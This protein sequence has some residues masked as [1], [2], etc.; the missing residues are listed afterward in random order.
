MVA[1]VTQGGE[2]VDDAIFW[3]AEEAEGYLRG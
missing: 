2:S 1:R 3:A